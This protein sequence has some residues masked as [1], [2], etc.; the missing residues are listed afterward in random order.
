VENRIS[1]FRGYTGLSLRALSKMSGV[2]VDEI[3]RVETGKHKISFEV[4]VRISEILHQPLSTLFPS[5]SVELSRLLSTVATAR[6]VA[7]DPEGRRIL[8]RLGF[9]VDEPGGNAARFYLRGGAVVELWVDS[10][11]ISSIRAQFQ[12]VAGD[13]II[14]FK[15][16]DGI[17]YRLNHEHVMCMM[18]RPGAPPDPVDG[19]PMISNWIDRLTVYLSDRPDPLRFKVLKDRSATIDP[20]ASD[21]DAQLNYLLFELDVGFEA[22]LD[23]VDRDCNAVV[24]PRHQVALL[25]VPDTKLADATT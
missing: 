3:R 12:Q 23:F 13:D 4:A 24:L 25:G 22:T 10:T 20:N 15:S 14:A 2:R 17:H 16:L 8:S 18:V 11:T 5:A 1:E 21:L 6:Q 19:P 9:E 7:L